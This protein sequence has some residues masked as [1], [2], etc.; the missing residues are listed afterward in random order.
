[1]NPTLGWLPRSRWCPA[2][3]ASACIPGDF[4][5]HPTIPKGQHWYSESTA[6][7][8]AQIQFAKDSNVKQALNPKAFSGE[9]QYNV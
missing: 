1:M 3:E 5:L 4:S 8:K 9:D 6:E 2:P 7:V